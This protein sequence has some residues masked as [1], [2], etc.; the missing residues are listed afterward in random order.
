MVPP[1]LKDA[2]FSPES[3]LPMVRDYLKYGDLLRD[4]R[5][6]K[7]KEIRWF[8]QRDNYNLQ[9]PCLVEYADGS[10]KQS[11]VPHVDFRIAQA[12]QVSQITDCF[13]VKPARFKFYISVLSIF[14][15]ITHK[16]SSCC[17]ICCAYF[18]CF[19]CTSEY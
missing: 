14:C 12:M 5:L 11:H 13:F 7:V 17:C 1:E 9:G 19:F 6:G 15:C 18:V 4:I 2:V 8:S 10:V 3:G 16:L